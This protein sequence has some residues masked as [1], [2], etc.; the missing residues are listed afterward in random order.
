MVE[1]SR[2]NYV[3]EITEID[4]ETASC[5]MI[6]M[7]VV[8]SEDNKSRLPTRFAK[9]VMIPNRNC[10]IANRWKKFRGFGTDFNFREASA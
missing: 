2:E 9:N 7:L 5:C 8:E 6:P 10:D 4:E 1:G 3:T